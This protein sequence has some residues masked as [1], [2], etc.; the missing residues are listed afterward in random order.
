[1]YVDL[2]DFLANTDDGAR[3]KE[4]LGKCVHCGFCTATCPTYQILG[5]EL[6]GPR[7]RIYQIKE[8]VEGAAATR[9]T[10]KHLDRCLTCLNCE[11]T[12]PSGVR[13]GQLVHIGKKIVDQQVERSLRERLSRALL[14]RILPYRKRIG[15]LVRLGQW[16]RFAL[17]STLRAKVY[18]RRDPGP[19]PSTQHDRFMISLDG[20]VQPSMA[21]AINASTARVF[22]KLGIRL[23][24]AA[25]SGC[26]GAASLH[27][28][29]EDQGL[30]FIRRN[31]DAWWPLVEQGAE[32]VVVNASGCGAIVKEYG[33]IMRNDP[34]YAVRAAKIA[35]LC[36]DPVEILR[37]EDL[38]ELNLIPPNRP[39]AFHPPCT[40][41]HAQKLGGS[42]ESLLSNLGFQLSPVRDSHLCCGSAG[43]YSLF[44]PELSKQLRDN[45]TRALEQGAPE[46]IA[47]ANI[48]CLYHLQGGTQ[49]P[50]VHWIELLD[51]SADK[52]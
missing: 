18:P 48:G 38:S 8:L 13:Y 37:N 4:I 6:D 47:T 40:L 16:F 2:A 30:Q 25:Q 12:C 35:S 26:C 1:M 43:T 24:D 49:T 14:M 22:D 34:D 50:V 21:P 20:C 36:V 42:V 9:N 44:Q 32:A 31:I 19:I 7:G 5:D 29:A 45:K 23:V 51:A 17:P 33:D 3:A 28:G 10:Q 52:L 15:L 27:T 46:K 39:I 11:T 41:Q